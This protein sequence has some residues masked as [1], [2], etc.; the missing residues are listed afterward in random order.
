MIRRPFYLGNLKLSSNIFYA[1]LAGCSDYPFR[2]MSSLYGPA[3]HFCEMVKMDA[4][5]RC[6]R[7]TF[8]LLDYSRDMHPIGAQ[9]CGSNP[10]IAGKA[11]KM[12]EEL[13]FD[14]LD[15]NCGCPVDKV[16]K[17][18]SGSGMLKAPLLI[19]ECLANMVASV[20]IPVTVKIRAG[21]DENSLVFQDIVKIAEDAG[22]KAIT[23]HA[24]TRK[25]AYTGDAVW[26]WICQA[27][28]VA[29]NILV[30]GNGDL[31]EP[32]D[33]LEMFEKTGCDAVLI[34]RGTMGQPWMVSDILALQETG[35]VPER[36]LED[37][38]EALKQ[39]FR[40]TR[41]YCSE[42]EAV[43]AMRRVGCWYFKKSKGTR[44][45]RDAISHAASIDEIERLI[46]D[47]VP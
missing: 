19:G 29:K 3:L 18:G 27:K 43:V 24:R 23:L 5:V 34:A 28:A 44:N 8:H 30:V 10:S 13:G 14:S 47:F 16:T 12:I 7:G 45:F 17:D 4:L 2:K 37:F 46:E 6:D 20:K 39:H 42:R 25:Q 40:Y 26:E 41:E 15:L 35:S 1:P 31:F 32:K 9:I 22:A 38:R 33:A 36:T 21:W 11:A